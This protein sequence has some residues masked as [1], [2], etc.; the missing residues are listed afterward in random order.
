[1]LMYHVVPVDR[2]E[3]DGQAED[4]FRDDDARIVY[5]CRHLSTEDRCTL[6]WHLLRRVQRPGLIAVPLLTF[7]AV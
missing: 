3:I 7:S 2:I 4:C 1:M 6:I 5:I